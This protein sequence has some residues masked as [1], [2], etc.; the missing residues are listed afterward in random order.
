M[1]EFIASLLLVCILLFIALGL[2]SIVENI[3]LSEIQFEYC[4]QHSETSLE[5]YKL[6]K[7]DLV[8]FYKRKINNER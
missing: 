3:A 5:E 6:C 8:T 2:V 7:S 1:R 4:K